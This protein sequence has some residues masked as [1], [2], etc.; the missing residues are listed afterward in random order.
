M[1]KRIL[2][3]QTIHKSKRKHSIKNYLFIETHERAAHGM[4]Q[5][6]LPIYNTAAS[7]AQLQSC[8][9]AGVAITHTSR[10]ET[11][12]LAHLNILTSVVEGLLSSR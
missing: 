5:K 12:A 6:T 11:Y 8:D 3:E 7:F 1:P 9:A 2:S 4:A 10:L